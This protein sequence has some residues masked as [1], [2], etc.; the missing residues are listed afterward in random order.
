MIRHLPLLL[1]IAFPLFSF[2]QG[3]PDT[4]RTRLAKHVQEFPQEKVYL[5]LDR[6]QYS[7]GDTIWFKAYITDAVAHLADTVSKNIYVD[8]FKKDNGKEING[9][10][11]KNMGG[12]SHGYLALVD[13]L[14]EGVYEIRGYTN[15]M[16]NFSGDYFFK[17]EVIIRRYI[18]RENEKPSSEIAD[19]QFF[20]EGG[21]LVAGL[22]GRVAFKAVNKFGKGVEFKA[23]V[24]SDK[25]TDPVA[26][27]QSKHLGMGTFIFNPKAGERYFAKVESSDKSN[28]PRLF[29][30]PEVMTQGY[31]LF[32]DN[33]SNK[34]LIRVVAKNNIPAKDRPIVVAHH[35]GEVLFAFQNQVEANAFSWSL[36]KADIPEGGIVQVTLFNGNGDPQCERLIYND[37]KDT[38]Q[39]AIR[40][41]K[42]EYKPHEKVT[43]QLEVKDVGGVPVQGNFSMSVVD[44]EQI[45]IDEKG[46][47]IYNYL[48]LTSDVSSLT[49]SEIKGTIEQPHYYFDKSNPNAAVDLDILLM[50]QGWRR[51]VWQNVLGKK[52]EKPAYDVETGISVKGKALKPNGKP[53]AKPVEISL[54]YHPEKGATEFVSANTDAQGKFSFNNLV[55]QGDGDAVVQGKKDG[56]GKDLLLTADEFKSPEFKPCPDAI[57][58]IQQKTVDANLIQ[59]YQDAELKRREGKVTVLKEV[60][61]TAQKKED[62]RKNYYEGIANKYSV[63]VSKETCGTAL[64][65]F[66]MI[67]GR[68]PGV[69]IT[70]NTTGVTTGYSV[71]IRGLTSFQGPTAPPAYLLDGVPV[72]PDVLNNIQPCSVESIDVVTHPVAMLNANGIISVLTRDAN[73]NYVGPREPAKG[74]I[75]TKLRGYQTAREFYSPKYVDATLKNKVPDFRS[76]LY[77]NPVIKTDDKGNATVT[78]WNSDEKTSVH[79]T[80]EGISRDGRPAY[81]KM[82]YQVE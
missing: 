54:V 15:W 50:T 48:N 13:S 79:V 9:L 32:I 78:F 33:L 37:T 52:T 22:A 47:N 68:V 3:S 63:P 80:L 62:K 2:S 60:V 8:F 81:A 39:I 31:S 25:A 4:I 23:F 44:A 75:I 73:P 36:K 20:P 55:V 42:T 46:M 12:Y 17:K 53:T 56:G 70:Q 10:M 72:T 38:L 34:D 45:D 43:L 49:N 74:I 35:R 6:P 24:F 77:W 64:S 28:L 5:H 40:P 67:Q 21:N 76:T 82:N 57:D 18:N 1:A 27:I 30:L 26:T 71:Q 7:P 29:Y 51:F 61:V 65:I 41:D 59:R 19:L 69:L 14:K 16:R 58:L 66:Q 11:L